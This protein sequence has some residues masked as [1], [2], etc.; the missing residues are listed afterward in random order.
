MAWTDPIDFTRNQNITAAIM[1]LYVRDNQ[2]DL[3][4]IVVK[5]TGDITKASS[6]AFSNLTGL[7][8]TVVSGEVWQF[9]VYSFFISNAAAD[10]K[11]TVTAPAA[12]T[13]RIGLTG[14]GA[15]ITVQS[16]TTFGGT[17][18]MVVPGVNADT[19]MLDGYVVAG[20]NGSMQVQAA[21]VTS[22]VVVTTFYANSF[23]IAQRISA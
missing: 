9:H 22:D 15:A 8:F 19:V 5:Q 12:S 1:N 16:T 2:N 14:S 20:A 11:W 18:D 4:T 17:L 3:W 23:L 6:T 7:T 21:Q 13:G 10:A